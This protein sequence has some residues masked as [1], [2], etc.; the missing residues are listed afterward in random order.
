M[1]ERDHRHWDLTLNESVKGDEDRL[2]KEVLDKVEGQSGAKVPI[3]AHL[4]SRHT[5]IEFS[6]HTD[7]N[8]CRQ[9]EDCQV[10]TGDDA[11]D[12]HS[13]EQFRTDDCSLVQNVCKDVCVGG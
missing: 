9:N 2:F 4:E 8:G 13:N 6:L 10:L 12:P 11:Q 1:E 3:Q 5:P 7:G